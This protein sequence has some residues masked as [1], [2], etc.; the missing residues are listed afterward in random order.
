MLAFFKETFDMLL[1]LFKGA[2]VPPYAGLYSNFMQYFRIEFPII[3]EL[4]LKNLSQEEVCKSL[5]QLFC[6]SAVFKGEVLSVLK[7]LAPALLATPGAYQQM[8]KTGGKIEPKM[9]GSIQSGMKLLLSTGITTVP[10][11]K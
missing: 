5:A 8:L 4:M 7:E 1:V 2:T 9:V 6:M 11:R 3:L 10:T